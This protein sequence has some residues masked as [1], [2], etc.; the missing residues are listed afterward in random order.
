LRQPVAQ[1]TGTNGPAPAPTAIAQQRPAAVPIKPSYQ[2][3]MTAFL[4]IAGRSAK[5]AEVTLGAEGGSVRFDS[6]DVAALATTL[7]IQAMRDGRI[8]WKEGEGQ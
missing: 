7:M 5:A 1:G 8:Q 3:A 2:R 4:I 6:R